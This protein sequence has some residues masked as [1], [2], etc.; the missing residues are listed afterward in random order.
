[1]IKLVGLK[2]GKGLG[3]VAPSAISAPNLLVIEV[4]P[5][6]NWVVDECETAEARARIE[7]ALQRLL[8]RP[9]SVR[10]DRSAEAGPRESPAQAATP[11]RRGDLAG[12][13]MV[14]KV[15]EL[16]EARPLHLEYEEDPPPSAS[17]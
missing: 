7:Q 16:F 4:P 9:V 14:Q 10:F 15:V 11:D 12:D 8:H 17:S 2:F 5:R 1:M 13:P 6:Y 3:L